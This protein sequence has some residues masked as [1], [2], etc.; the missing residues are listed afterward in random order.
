MRVEDSTTH[1]CPDLRDHVEFRCDVHPEAASC[2]DY[3]IGY[4]QTFD[5]YGLWI[6]DGADGEPS[7]WIV[8]QYCPFCGA[9]QPPNRRDEWFDRLHA[10]GLEPE[11]APG[12][13]RRYGWWLHG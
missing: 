11:D 2:A 7:S 8:I 4:N 10:L 1:C 9:K 13:L 6:H 3:L 12:H 5:E